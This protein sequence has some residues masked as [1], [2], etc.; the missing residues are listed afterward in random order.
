MGCRTAYPSPALSSIA[1]SELT[2]N[3][4]DLLVPSEPGRWSPRLSASVVIPYFEAFEALRHTLIGVFTQSYPSGLLEVVVVD[5]GSATPLG[6]DDVADLGEVRVVRREDEGFRPATSRN[7]GAAAATGDV[8]VFLDGD[9]IPDPS[10]LEHHMRWHHVTDDAMVLG[11]RHHVDDS[12]L[13]ED[14]VRQAQGSG[15]LASVVA[16]RTVE[17]P[18]W[19]EFHMLR[20]K[21]LTTA[22][23]DLFRVV[24]SGNVSVRRETFDRIGGFDDSFIRWGHEDT[25]FGYR[26]WVSGA[27]LIPERGAHCWHQGLGTSPDPDERTA[28]RQQAKKLAHLVPHP[29]IRPSSQGRNWQRPRIVVVVGTGTPEQVAGTTRALLACEDLQV[30]VASNGEAG[31]LEDFGPEPRVHLDLEPGEVSPFSPLRCQIPAGLEPT[32]KLITQLAD[33]A[34]KHGR[35]TSV[36]GISMISAR[37]EARGEIAMRQVGKRAKRTRR[38][39]TISRVLRRLSRVRS[40]SDARS[41]VRWL[42]AAVRRKM[43]AARGRGITEPTVTARLPARLA[44]DPWTRV[45]APDYPSLPASG[46]PGERLDLV[47]L[48][49]AGD[50]SG[51]VP[52]LVVGDHPDRDL[53]THPPL[54]PADALAVIRGE[55]DSGTAV[56]AMLLGQ[57]P[58]TPP[59]G[60]KSKRAWELLAEIVST[61]DEPVIEAVRR[62]VLIEH[63]NLPRL[64]QLRSAAGL[65]SIMPRVSVV[66]CTR[67]IDQ[68][69]QVVA[70]MTRQTYPRM[71]IIVVGHGRDPGP[72]RSVLESA[73]VQHRLLT[74]GEEVP[75]GAALAVGSREASGDLIAK[76]DD[77]DLYAITHIEDLVIARLLSGADLVGKSA[78]FVMLKEQGLTIRRIFVKGAYGPSQTLAG[79]TLAITREAYDAV[80]G[81]RPLDRHVDRALIDDVVTSGRT[82]FRTHGFGYVLVRHGDHTWQVDDQELLDQAEERWSELPSWVL[83]SPLAP[84]P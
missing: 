84:A 72:I 36:D 21:D 37:H 40:W 68:A 28:Q 35:A 53:L 38:P 19:I 45:Y 57:A 74:V 80:G 49:A 64:D 81:W 50:S 6:A 1:V 30:V 78:E 63:L 65:P 79:G 51:S 42:V 61:D 75:F 20:T 77:D 4:W 18:E 67:R 60:P 27:L 15:G 41:V 13:T 73:S 44:V 48:S 58:Q 69:R 16:D 66:L 56:T 54:E 62:S 24:T 5:D 3:R 2:T 26:G 32:P 76:V 14:L 47:V 71:E 7:E 39:G 31:L 8:L 59:P 52:A 25:E 9:M 29:T 70:Q 17:R 83:E 46:K 22:D 12:W 23:T 82:A 11:F 55:K 43:S 10:W 33:T 34:V